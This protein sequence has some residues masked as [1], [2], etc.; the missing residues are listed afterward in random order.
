MHVNCIDKCVNEIKHDVPVLEVD[1]SN[2]SAFYCGDVL[3]LIGD[4]FKNYG[5]WQRNELAV[6]NEQ[7]SE[8]VAQALVGK[9]YQ[10]HDDGTLES[11]I[12]DDELRMHLKPRWCQTP[13]EQIEFYNRMLEI[14]DSRI[15]AKRKAAA[16]RAE[17]QRI[18][19]E[20][21]AL[22]NS[23]TA[24]EKEALLKKKREKE[25]ESLID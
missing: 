25:V 1:G 8:A 17:A 4:E 13:S 18:A 16:E 7:N 5:G 15:E 3:H 10:S 19:D 23:L 20:K 9:L 2:A 24:E 22:W 6:I 11:D 14:R 12:P 21:D